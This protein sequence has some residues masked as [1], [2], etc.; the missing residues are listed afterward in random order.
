MTVPRPRTNT[1]IVARDAPTPC[2]ESNKPMIKMP[3]T[4]RLLVAASL[5][6]IIGLNGCVVG[7]TAYYPDYGPGGY[8]YLYYPSSGIYYDNLGGYYYYPSGG[9]WIQT[10]VLPTYLYSGLGTY[11]VLNNP[12]PRPWY[13]YDEHRRYYPPESYRHHPPKPP[14]PRPKPHWDDH[15]PGD[16]PS[17][18]WRPPPGHQPPGDRPPPKPPGGG[19]PRPDDRPPP[20]DR[21]WPGGKP[22]PDRPWSGGKPPPGDR[23][24]SEGKPPPG[25]RPPSGPAGGSSPRPVPGSGAV[26]LPWALGEGQDPGPAPAVR[27]VG[28]LSPGRPWNQGPAS[29]MP[30]VG[31]PPPPSPVR[32]PVQSPFQPPAQPHVQS[33]NKPPAGW[34]GVAP[35]THTPSPGSRPPIAPGPTPG[36]RPVAAPPPQQA[37]VAK[38]AQGLYR[39][40]AKPSDNWGGTPDTGREGSGGQ[41]PPRGPGGGFTPSFNVNY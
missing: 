23:P 31:R 38:P 5:A 24:W 39:P 18:G 28:G 13:R 26:T 30:E 36:P 2:Q 10:T 33:L 19:W 17:S 9:T 41:A 8:D 40:G 22:P 11:V 32:P 6:A 14:P 7:T 1:Q 16:K 3:A 35:V 25:A 29:G 27:P 37:P 15:R 20:G 12:G 21:P 4:P 34:P